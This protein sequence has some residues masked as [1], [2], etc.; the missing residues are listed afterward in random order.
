MPYGPPL[1]GIIWCIYLFANMGG[2]GGQNYFQII[3]THCSLCRIVPR[4]MLLNTSR[5]W[6]PICSIET[7]RARNLPKT[8]S[9]WTRKIISECRRRGGCGL[10]GGVSPHQNHPN[11]QNRQWSRGLCYHAYYSRTIVLL[12]LRVGRTA[13]TV[14]TVKRYTPLDHTPPF[15]RIDH[16]EGMLAIFSVFGHDGSGTAQHGPKALR[17]MN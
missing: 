17:T 16:R 6:I 5:T 9:E 7:W 3:I 11:R 8:D 1:Y 14:K 4:K 2:G 13:K 12:P 15:G 10:G